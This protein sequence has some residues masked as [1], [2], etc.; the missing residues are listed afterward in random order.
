MPVMSPFDLEDQRAYRDWRD[1]KLAAFPASPED[2]RIAVARPDAPAAQDVAAIADR[3][4]RANLALYTIEP[5]PSPS[6]ARRVLPRFAAA[7][8][9]RDHERHRSSDADGVVALEVTEKRGRGGFIPYTNRPL[10]W[11]TDGYYNDPKTPVRAFLL[12]CVRPASSGGENRLLDPDIAYI[13]LRDRDPA[14][15]KALMHPCA[16]TIPAHTEEDGSVRPAAIGPVF[17]VDK[18]SGGLTM[19]YT[20]RARNVVWR[21]DADTTRA[22]EVLN[23]LLRDGDPLMFSHRLESGQGIICNNVLHC[24]SGFEDAT[25]GGGRLLLRM[26]FDRRIAPPDA[27]TQAEEN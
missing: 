20:A 12:H 9:L 24:R 6:E 7:L 19:R 27:G 5:T 1:A 13:R 21:D 22:V 8:G 4:R 2:C 15:I 23:A 26:R 3:C 10:N 16:M 18:A 17:S 14:L 25:E 11:H